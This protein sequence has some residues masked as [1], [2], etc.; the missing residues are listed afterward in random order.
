M[1]AGGQNKSDRLPAAEMLSP[2]GFG[3]TGT[4]PVIT[5]NGNSSGAE[6][7]KIHYFPGN[8]Y[9]LGIH[10]IGILHPGMEE[11][12][13]WKNGSSATLLLCSY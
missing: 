2:G 10:F 6:H 13:R 8:I 1:P 11:K 5:G 9:F 3:A 4:A 7:K 12:E